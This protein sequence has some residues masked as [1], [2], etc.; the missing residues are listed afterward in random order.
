MKLNLLWG[1]NPRNGYTN[2]DPF[3]FGDEQK[4][5]GSLH[6]LN[7]IVDD[8]EAEE[9]IAEDVIDFLP[10]DSVVETIQHWISKLCH[11]GTLIIG[12]VDAYE[13]A[14]AF[15]NYEINLADLNY[16]LHGK[17][18]EPHQ[19][20]LTNFTLVGLRDLLMENGMKIIKCRGTAF[21]EASTERNLYMFIEARRP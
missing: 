11:G 1:T 14:R 6:Q 7:D 16:L 20:K 5:L 9:I 4:T 19:Q 21:N 17:Q 18:E 15:A 13:V 2:V 3:G 8:N 12:G 10:R